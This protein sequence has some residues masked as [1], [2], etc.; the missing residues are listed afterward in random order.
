MKT[1][2][3]PYY[4][5]EAVDYGSRHPCGTLIAED[6]P[7]TTSSW[8]GVDCLRCLKMKEKLQRGYEQEEKEICRQLGDMAEFF[9][10][11]NG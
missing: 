9:E 5:W 8:N 6:D 4:D 10:K 3:D 2:F 11:Q 1:H 7:Q